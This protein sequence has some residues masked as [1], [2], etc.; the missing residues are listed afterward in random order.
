MIRHQLSG[1]GSSGEGS[2]S[3]FSSF[4]H[5]TSWRAFS[6]RMEILAHLLRSVAAPR[7]N[8]SAYSSR[9]HHRAS[10]RPSPP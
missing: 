5:P 10:V 1:P 2:G 9:F 8:C 6:G 7:S 4:N 3:S